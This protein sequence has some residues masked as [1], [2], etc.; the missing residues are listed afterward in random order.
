MSSI[1]Y[2]YSPSI[3]LPKKSKRNTSY[4][5][6]NCCL[7]NESDSEDEYESNTSYGCLF[8]ESDSSDISE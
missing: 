2:G 6:N 8:N 7:F 4:E 5:N 1:L 3:S